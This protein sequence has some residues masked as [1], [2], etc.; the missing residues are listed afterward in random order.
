MRKETHKW[1]L[2]F[3]PNVIRTNPRLAGLRS[4]L[5][6]LYSFLGSLRLTFTHSLAH[7]D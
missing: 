7:F 4:G 2:S 6:D 1:I 5:L 3:R